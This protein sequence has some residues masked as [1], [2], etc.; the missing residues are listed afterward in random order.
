MEAN[1]AAFRAG[2]SFGETSELI[3]VQ[4][5]GRAATPTSC[6][7]RTATSTARRRRRSASSPRRSR[8]GCRCVLGAYP[9]TPASELL[10]EL[11]RRQDLGVRT[12]QAEDEIAAAS[13]ALGAAFG[14]ALG[15][16]AHERARAGPQD[17]DDRA[18]RDARAA[19][20][21]HRRPARRP[22]DR[23]ADQDRAVRPAAGALRP[24]RRVAAAGD[25]RRRRPGQCFDAIYRGGADR[26]HLP[27]AGDPPERPVRRQ[28]ERAVEDPVGRRPAA[29]STRTSARRR[30]T[31]ACRSC[32]TRAT[33]ASPAPW[34]I[35]GTPGLAHRIGGLEKQD[36]TGAISYDGANHA[37]HD[38]PARG[39]GRRHRGARPRGPRRRGRRPAGPRLGLELR[40]DPRRRAPRRARAAGASPSP[41]CTTSTRCRPTPA[42]VLRAYER[43]L[44]PEMNS[45]QLAKSCAREYLVDVES[46]RE[47]AGPAAVAAEIETGDPGSA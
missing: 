23:P 31:R 2:W 32:P 24:P 14:G 17:G 30:A 27:H 29:R 8:A 19:D 41:T 20:D 21:H 18:R 16:T 34:A 37:A 9:I 44:L 25:R 43:V 35:P 6:P 46:L 15:V 26:G 40:H 4:V 7:A 13:I 45:G 28:L 1:L 39:E 11:S 10:H 36:G 42:S 33:T 12:I 3:D 38:R 47:G 22:V 5:H